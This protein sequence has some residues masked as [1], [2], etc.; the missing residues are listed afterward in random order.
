MVLNDFQYDFR[1][2]CDTADSAYAYFPCTGL[3]LEILATTF[4]ESL[5]LAARNLIKLTG[6]ICPNWQICGN[7]MKSIISYSRTER[8][9]VTRV[10]ENFRSKA[11][12]NFDNLNIVVLQ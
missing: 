11:G 6:N 5:T 10:S 8:V 2:I 7:S 1:H 9:V 4:E 3:T 12:K